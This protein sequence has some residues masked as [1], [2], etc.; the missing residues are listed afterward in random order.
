MKSNEKMKNL[1]DW[2]KIDIENSLVTD[3]LMIIKINLIIMSPRNLFPMKNII[4]N[5]G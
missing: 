5:N 1:F 2:R 3:I 4:I